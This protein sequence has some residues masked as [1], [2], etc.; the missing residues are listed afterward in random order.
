[1]AVRVFRIG[2]VGIICISRGC[3]LEGQS[4]NPGVEF[5]TLWPHPGEATR[6]S[7]WSSNQVRGSDENS[8]L[9]MMHVDKNVI[10]GVAQKRFAG[11]WVLPWE[12][13]RSGG[14]GNGR[15]A[16][17]DVLSGTRTAPLK[18]GGRGV[19]SSSG[20]GPGRQVPPGGGPVSEQVA[21]ASDAQDAYSQQRC[22]C[23]PEYKWTR[24]AAG[25]V[26]T[27]VAP[28]R[29]EGPQCTS[30]PETVGARVGAPVLRHLGAPRRPGAQSVRP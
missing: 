13:A 7:C 28:R 11:Y 19:H 25:T 22:W 12:V 1:M 4:L 5:L 14:S 20:S 2:P 30:G 16:E 21:V 18:L 10:L 17:A 24:G 8:S 6:L 27:V 29:L 23:Y 9:E 26:G 3:C 15:P